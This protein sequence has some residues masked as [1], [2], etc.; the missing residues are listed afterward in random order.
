MILQKEFKT[1]RVKL[2]EY[3][4]ENSSLL[5]NGDKLKPEISVTKEVRDY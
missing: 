4:Y 2:I 5:I 1:E 3:E